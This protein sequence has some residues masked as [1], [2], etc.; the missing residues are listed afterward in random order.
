MLEA[1]MQIGL[2]RS[3]FHYHHIILYEIWGRC[4]KDKANPEATTCVGIGSVVAIAIDIVV[5]NVTG[6]M[7][8]KARHE[9]M[10]W[11]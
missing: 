1:S 8:H 7:H 3:P 4:F 10:N 9:W 6:E 5:E 11:T 2:Q